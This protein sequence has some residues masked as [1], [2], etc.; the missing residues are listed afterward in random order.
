VHKVLIVEDDAN[1]RRLIRDSLEPAGYDIVE[2]VKGELGLV[3][4]AQEQPDVLVLDV[5]MP[6]DTDGLE[7]CRRAKATP[8]LAQTKVLMLS[9]RGDAADLERGAQAGADAYLV[10][11]FS[12]IE[13]ARAVSELLAVQDVAP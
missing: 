3:V 13:L 9:A 4:A 11:P 8:S 10:K 7:V 6:G 12:P 1:I 5:M 2:A